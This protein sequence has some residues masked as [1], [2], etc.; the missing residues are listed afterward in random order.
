M[1]SAQCRAPGIRAPGISR[2]RGGRAL[3]SLVEP[4]GACLAPAFFLVPGFRFLR[5]AAPG[6]A[7]AASGGF[8]LSSE[9]MSASLS[10]TARR[11]SARSRASEFRGVEQRRTAGRHARP[12]WT[13]RMVVWPV[14]LNTENIT[15]P[16]VKTFYTPTRSGFHRSRFSASTARQVAS[17]ACRS[18][19][20]ALRPP[21]GSSCRGCCHPASR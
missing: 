4:L 6:A 2:P 20:C 12:K 17:P 7:S 10:R 15:Q 9:P 1:S 8:G 19:T 13:T 16:Q 18:R 3:H 14:S 11:A 5:P 21:R